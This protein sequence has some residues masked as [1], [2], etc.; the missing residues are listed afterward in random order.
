M[1]E[2]NKKEECLCQASPCV[3]AADVFDLEEH[4][5]QCAN[6][7][8][9]EC[10]FDQLFAAIGDLPVLEAP[11]NFEYS[12][13]SRIVHL[14]DTGCALEMRV[15]D[16]ARSSL[17]GTILLLVSAG[18]VYWFFK[19]PHGGTLRLKQDP[20]R[21]LGS[22]GFLAPALS[23]QGRAVRILAGMSGLAAALMMALSTRDNSKG[24]K[25]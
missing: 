18:T 22:T 5:V 25:A 3:P 6:C 23:K 11:D 7:Q 8:A 15:W 24:D 9:E 4:F 2:Q 16:K 19:E 21:L 1:R 12:V 13:M 20:P 14:N 17:V 10:F